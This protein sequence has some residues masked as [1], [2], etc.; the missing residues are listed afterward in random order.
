MYRENDN[1]H[2]MHS[3]ERQFFR[4][5]MKQIDYKSFDVFNP[6]FSSNTPLGSVMTTMTVEELIMAF[7]KKKGMDPEV[8]G[9]Q[10]LFYMRKWPFLLNPV[11]PYKNNHDKVFIALNKIPRRYKDIIPERVIGKLIS[12]S[13]GEGRNRIISEFRLEG[14]K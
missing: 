3:L 10:L 8:K 9:K 7:C 6:Y 11:D 5:V 1:S 2:L 13:S 12:N 4:F 14:L